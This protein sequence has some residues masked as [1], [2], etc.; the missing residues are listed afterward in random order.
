MKDYEAMTDLEAIEEACI[1]WLGIVNRQIE[2]EGALN[3]A[4]CQKY[5]NWYCSGCPVKKF[6]NCN[7][8]RNTPY[9]RWDLYI[10]KV[11]EKSILTAQEEFE[12]LMKLRDTYLVKEATK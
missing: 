3:C 10:N 7:G 6:T 11:D 9:S 12:F 5:S 4:L 8:C 1:K 2:D